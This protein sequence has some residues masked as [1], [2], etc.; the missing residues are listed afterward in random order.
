MLHHGNIGLEINKTNTQPFTKPRVGF[1]WSN[2][3]AQFD[4]TRARAYNSKDKYPQ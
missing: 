3:R 2:Q 1:Q 4:K